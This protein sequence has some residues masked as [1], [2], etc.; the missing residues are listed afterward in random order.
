MMKISIAHKLLPAVALFLSA[1]M[2]FA[3][4]NVGVELEGSSSS[5]KRLKASCQPASASA[6]LDVNNVRGRIMNGG[7]MWWDLVGTAKYEVP[8]V[9]EGSEEASKTS[10]F[11]G[12]VWIGGLYNGNIHTAA[13]TY[14]QNGV[15]FWPGALDEGNAAVTE[16]D[17]NYWDRIFE[18]TREEIDAHIELFAESED[19][20]IESQRI[21][22][23]PGNGRG[24][25]TH[26]KFTMAPYVNIA[27]GPEY[28]PELGDY[29]D[30]K[31]DQALWYVYNDAGNI[32]RQSSAEEIGIE[33]QTMAFAFA[34]SD[35]VN[36][37]TFYETTIHNMGNKTLD[38]CFFGQWVDADLGYAY[39]DYV[40][41]DV[42]RGLGICFNG[43][44]FDEGAFG[45]GSNPPSIGVDFFQGPQADLEVILTGETGDGIDNDG[46]GLVD[47][48]D[49]TY[50]WWYRLN[51]WAEEDLPIGYEGDG[52][53]NNRDGN[54]DEPGEDIIMSKF[55]YYNNDF[56]PNGNPRANPVHHYNYLQGKWKNGD[57]IKF[58]GNGF[59]DF[60]GDCTDFMFPDDPRDADGWSEVTSNNQPADRRFLQTAG[61]FS[62]KVGAVNTVTV[63]VVWAR[64]T[65]GGNTGSYDQLLLADDKAQKLFNNSFKLL[66]G[67]DAPTMRAVEL[68]KE[69]ILIMD[70]KEY[71]ETEVYED[72]EV[73][74]D[75]SEVVYTFQGYQ[76][77]QLANSQVA[78]DQIDDPDL[79]REVWES[80]IKDGIGL[81]V[82]QEFDP[83]VSDKISVIKV[84]GNDA[85][86]AHTIQ[87]KTDVFA[88]GNTDFVN[89]KTYHYLLLAYAAADEESASEDRQYLEGRRSFRI[90]VTPRQ[91][92]IVLGGTQLN[93]EF[94]DGPE[95]TR[96]EGNGNGGI[97]LD[98]T[99]GAVDEI[100]ENG[101]IPHPI[102]T[103][104]HGPVNVKVIDPF[105]LEGSNFELRFIDST[106]RNTN[107]RQLAINIETY[108]RNFNTATAAYV[109]SL[110]KFNSAK[111]NIDYIA[112]LRD[113][114][115]LMDSLET[116]FYPSEI[117]R[118]NDTIDSL[119]GLYITEDSLQTLKDSNQVLLAAIKVAEDNNDDPLAAQ[120][121]ADRQTIIPII[122]Y[123]NRL[124]KQV[125][126]TWEPEIVS[127]NKEI[128]IAK[129]IKL[130]LQREI[131]EKEPGYIKA[132][133]EAEDDLNDD[134][135]DLNER[136]DTLNL[137]TEEAEKVI[138]ELVRKS[139]AG[140]DTI[141]AERP[142]YIENEM[143]IDEWGFSIKVGPVFAPGESGEDESNG[144]LE[145]SIEY[146]DDTKTWLAA[147][148]DRDGTGN[149]NKPDPLDWI[150]AGSNR[151]SA[152]G[153][154]SDE[155][156]HDVRYAV[157]N[158]F[159]TLDEGSVYE[160]VIGGMIAPYVLASRSTT[161]NGF[162]TFGI[163]LS[164]GYTIEEMSD[165]EI[166]PSIDLVFTNDRSKWTRC[167]VAEMG[168][169]PTKTEGGVHKFRMRDHASLELDPDADGNPVYSTT[170]KGLS[171]FPGYAIDVETG[172]RLNIIMGENSSLNKPNTRDMIWNP[173]TEL[174]DD[175][176]RG[177]RFDLDG[178][179]V[180]GGMH[181]IYIMKST[182][183]YPR[184]IPSGQDKNGIAYDEGKLYSSIMKDDGRSEP[185]LEL[186][187]VWNSC[188]WVMPA[189][190]NSGSSLR[191]FEDGLVPTETKIRLRVNTPYQTRRVN[192]P[193]E[194]ENMPYFTFGTAD[195]AP[196]FTVDAGSEALKDVRVVP[197]PYYAF[198]AY[199][200][201]Q[202]D[203]TVK[204]TNLP[205]SCTVKI[206]TVNGQ[207]VKKIE[208]DE[209]LAADHTTEVRW[210]LKNDVGVPIASGVY[211]IHID[212]G[213]LGENTI[214][215]FAALRP[216]DL[217][218]F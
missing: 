67:P 11:A 173:S 183:E 180:V 209:P 111:E 202:I 46:D 38:S 60:T 30:V 49:T 6:D 214:K 88:S 141:R 143:V 198:S 153:D 131:D 92:G 94:G 40:G 211:V 20:Q 54:I 192:S 73:T 109:S 184:G 13:M 18:V 115:A 176:G 213:E 7:D 65:S 14:R 171:W 166:L 86:V 191:S 132:F 78:N 114:I 35:E 149:E 62:L 75:G 77:F 22:D 66:D 59:S 128:E 33:M 31:G 105:K 164:S 96:M 47:E 154:P 34:T 116:K 197:N 61:P 201:T 203:N 157:A 26:E 161:L 100:L 135:D 199:E 140:N 205:P 206:Y 151:P 196:E 162:S 121:E 12:S 190:L 145:G 84:D 95:I 185:S 193:A 15:D 23:W 43:D 160:D 64:A 146:E 127:I 163:S 28:E 48:N 21:K 169:D 81:L 204:L 119:M 174:T 101:S 195:I 187:G 181:Y 152:A 212:A 138:W 134:I 186:R 1:S 29:P 144:F 122:Q 17:C 76:L 98:L 150:R 68:D 3:D 79:A 133:N 113:S 24:G 55:V 129:A 85:G 42:D 50:H 53:D 156:F 19:P 200:Q 178:G 45:Y 112:R 155:A 91:T 167:V 97:S 118:V 110:G 52:I 32:K 147:L 159:T 170:S 177:I 41:C 188:G 124:R 72:R 125:D 117:V 182:S 63:G 172:E 217:D 8:K 2:A 120:L 58:G 207:L 25:E 10:L 93:S 137:K 56:Q 16:E 83:A 106:V 123:Q 218:T 158:G 165:F 82:N 44:N 4:K 99:D 39:D 108:E 216:V 9:P 5:F 89:H 136:R 27:G 90:S 139:D 103:N 210:D 70:R 69:V 104:G 194:N 189:Y 148:P 87:L 168:E 215:F 37:M 107:G 57:C 74:T 126:E 36:N 130:L 175:N 71:V 208:R 102:Y 179:L 80:D 142:L 51:G